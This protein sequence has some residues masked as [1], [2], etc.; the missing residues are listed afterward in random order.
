MDKMYVNI[1]KYG[2]TTAA[3]IPI[4]MCEALEGKGKIFQRGYYFLTAF[5]AGYTWASAAIRW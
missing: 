3:T 5:G 4:A 1:H 2:N